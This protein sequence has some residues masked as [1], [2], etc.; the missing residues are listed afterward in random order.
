MMMAGKVAIVAHFDPNGGIEP[1]L[2]EMM[3]CLER[4]F[5]RVLFV[6]TSAVD[7]V[8]LSTLTR[9][10]MIVRP[11]IGYDFYSYRVGLD[12]VRRVGGAEQVLLLNTSILVLDPAKFTAALRR[13]VE[14]A[15]T[16]DAVGATRSRQFAEH[17]QSY[18][19]L[20]GRPVLEASWFQAFVN[21]IEP[22]GD[23]MEIVRRYELGLT[24]L[25]KDNGA[26]I[27]ALFA[28]DAEQVK[29]AKAAWLRWRKAN[30]ATWQGLRPRTA[31]AAD[32][33]N[34]IQFHAEDIARSLGF[35]KAEVLR[36][37]PHDIDLAFVGEVAGAETKAGI[38]RLLDRS[39]QHYVVAEPGKLA[40]V[41]AATTPIPTARTAVWGTPR[42]RGI[43]LAVV[44]HAFFPDVLEEIVAQF[45]HIVE[46]FDLYVTTPHEELASPILRLG[47]S[48][49]TSVTVAITEN[50][51]RDIGPFLNL[52]RSGA[53]DRYLAVLKLHTKKS[54]YSGQGD[55]WRRGLVDELI[56]DSLKVRR[57]VSLFETGAVGIVGP[58][59]DYLSH[60]SFWGSNRAKVAT[61]LEGLGAPS[62]AKAHL[63]FFAGS[64]FWFAPQALKPLHAI[65]EQELA[66]DQELG[67]QDGTLAH[68]LERVFA[69]LARAQGLR[70]TSLALKGAEVADTDTSGN[71]V[72]VL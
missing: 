49:A 42:A 29:S 33:Y 53:F 52:L 32:Q 22:L 63:G 12:R 10:E 19:L 40:T 64:M 72:P 4:V 41:A 62:G 68:A 8:A 65:P 18:M 54:R 17:L 59:G 15:Q 36:D 66:F 6:S 56:G 35:V 50:R 45:P 61:L 9:T 60:P 46:P 11:N 70:T 23:K 37:N 43:R 21:A 51:G 69:P 48:H 14:L 67:Q 2:V 1:T 57:A 58:H 34:P 7:P 30:G 5:D 24:A 25:L 13:M 39:H 55:A 71:R 28:P 47:A 27:T 38:E 26:N 3:T 16:H 20:L 31:S 44:V